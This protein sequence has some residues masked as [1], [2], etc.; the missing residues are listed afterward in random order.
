MSTFTIIR[1]NVDQKKKTRKKY[2]LRQME[3]LLMSGKVLNSS[4]S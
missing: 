2:I 1:M 4:Q 3:Y